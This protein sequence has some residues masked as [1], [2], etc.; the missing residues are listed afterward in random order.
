MYNKTFF[1]MLFFILISISVQAN[2]PEPS[3]AG[4]NYLELDGK[5]DYAVLDFDKFG[6]LFK[7]GTKD[8]TVEAWIYPTSMPE[9]DTIAVL[10]RQQVEIEVFGDDIQSYQ[11]INERI[12][13]KKGDLLLFKIGRAHV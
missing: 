7:E 13:W 3:P 12:G 1:L 2:L 11:E 5:D 4:G 10:F 6:A 8:L 9:G